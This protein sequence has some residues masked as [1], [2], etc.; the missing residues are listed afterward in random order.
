M[1][2][3]KFISL[4]AVFILSCSSDGEPSNSGGSKGNDIKN[5]KTVVIGTQT[6][7]AENLD[8]DV[9]GSKCY[10]D[11]PENCVKYGR[12]YSWITAMGLDSSDL[13]GFSCNLGSGCPDRELANH[14]GICPSGWHI[15][16]ETEWTTLIDY[17]GGVDMAGKNLKAKNGWSNNGNGVDEYGFT[18]LP[19]GLYSDSDDSFEAVGDFGCWWS[20]NYSFSAYGHFITGGDWVNRN[21]DDGRGLFFNVRCVKN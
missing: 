20:A 10:D 21:Y 8:Y 4:A 1:N 18:A 14:Q 17:A 2:K 16:S 5:Y 19:G 15:P 6:W 3:I 9:E 11:K 12:L 7:M 13:S